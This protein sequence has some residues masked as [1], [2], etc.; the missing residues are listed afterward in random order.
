MITLWMHTNEH[1]DGCHVISLYENRDTAYD[2]MK[3]FIGHDE[4]KY[5]A[6]ALKSEDGDF[7]CIAPVHL[8]DDE[9]LDWEIKSFA[10]E[11][12]FVWVKVSGTAAEA[13][14]LWREQ[15]KETRSKLRLRFVE[16]NRVTIDF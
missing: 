1:V 5:G 15:E 2:R 10:N 8:E 6:D 13:L 14:A 16:V 12:P 11:S 3:D 7:S 9:R 4:F